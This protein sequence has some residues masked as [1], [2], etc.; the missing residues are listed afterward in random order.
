M[1]Y[2]V[3]L[4]T[5]M[6]E[7]YVGGQSAT[8]ATISGFS[9]SA[10]VVTAAALI[11]VSVFSAFLSSEALVIKSLAFALA[12]GILFDAFLIRMTAVP[13]IHR[14]LGKRAW[15]LPEALS[16]RL[17]N[18]DVDGASLALSSRDADGRQ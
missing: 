11:M 15:W 6:R 9:A 3:F 16:K 12:F 5:R 7:A 14:L 1:D 4:V 10:R 17:P 2:E 18:P 13:A 8:D